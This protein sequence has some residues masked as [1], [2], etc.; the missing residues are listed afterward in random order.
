MIMNIFLQVQLNF[1]ENM[2]GLQI[3]V[4]G[5]VTQTSLIINITYKLIIDQKT[6][7]KICGSSNCVIS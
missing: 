4:V 3:L 6:P 2:V 1:K 7:K 5:T